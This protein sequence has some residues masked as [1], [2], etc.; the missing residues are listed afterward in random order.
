LK[1]GNNQE[2]SS[3][4][5]SLTNPLLLVFWMRQV[6]FLA[7]ECR[8]SHQSRFPLV[9]RVAAKKPASNPAARQARLAKIVQG[10]IQQKPTPVIAAEIGISRQMVNRELRDPDNQPLIQSLFQPHHERL[11]KCVE[12]QIANVE[13]ALTMDEAPRLA[14]IEWLTDRITRM[15]K[16]IEERAESPVT[17][18]VAGGSTGLIVHQERVIGSGE[19]ARF[20]DEY[21]I[22]TGLL[23]ELREHEKQLRDELN[24]FSPNLKAVERARD[25]LEMAEGT[26]K[27]GDSGKQLRWSGE[28]TELLAIYARIETSE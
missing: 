4:I 8:I 21:E 3:I 10:R 23:K 20:V 13:R 5:F 25:L 19:S 7:I 24:D 14:R 2:L 1:A 16:V 28:L 22:D 27:D 12:R 6:R 9:S 11:R 15:R 26:R 17:A 18:S